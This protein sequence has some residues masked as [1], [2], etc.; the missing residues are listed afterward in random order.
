MSAEPAL[1]AR[2]FV[3]DRFFSWL[4]TPV[5]VLRLELV[6]FA[7]PLAMKRKDGEYILFAEDDG[8]Q[9]VNMF[10]WRPEARR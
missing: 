9:K 10:R 8:A 2:M 7:A 1:R 3:G 5:P 4:R 6:R